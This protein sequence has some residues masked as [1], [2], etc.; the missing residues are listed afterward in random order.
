MSSAISRVW[1]VSKIKH[2]E[3]RTKDDRHLGGESHET[4][5][6]TLH[7]WPCSPLECGASPTGFPSRICTKYFVNVTK[8]QSQNIRVSDLLSCATETR[9][10]VDVG[11]NR[12]IHASPSVLLAGFDINLQTLNLLSWIRSPFRGPI[13]VLQHKNQSKQVQSRL[14]D[15]AII[16]STAVHIA[17]CGTRLWN[18]CRLQSASLHKVPQ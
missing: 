3:R 9:L 4:Q 12:E 11:A 7:V 8:L 6:K 18:P 5:G 15:H 10:A 14:A 17:S 13:R 2:R 1:R 16:T